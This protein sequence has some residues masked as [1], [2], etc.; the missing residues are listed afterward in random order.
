MKQRYF[1]FPLCAL[2]FAADIQERL[3]CIISFGCVELGKK[4]WRTFNATEKQLRRSD[5]PSRHTCPCP[6]DLTKDEHLQ[7]AAGAERLHIKIPNIE[8]VLAGHATLS[9]FIKE[10][11]A[12]CGR[13]AQ[14]RIR[15]DW[16]F[17]A[18]DGKGMSYGELAV[19]AAIYSKIGASQRPVQISRDEIWKRAHGFKSDRV[20][21]Q[22]MSGRSPFITPRQVRSLTDRLYDRRFFARVT[23]ARRHTYYSHRMTNEELSE[24]VFQLKTRRDLARQVSR[25]AN[26]EL[27]RRIQAERR[28]LAT[29]KE[30][31]VIG[32]A[33]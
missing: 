15:T 7:V 25:M 5:L 17:E 26:E 13:D 16:I 33:T 28:K 4:Q 24:A 11:E 19:L 1:Q 3:N 27:T 29:L 12:R 6:I 8:R 14:V 22:E 30:Q 31:C 20:F 10:F 32:A 21:R 18:R 2:S 9:R 23:Y